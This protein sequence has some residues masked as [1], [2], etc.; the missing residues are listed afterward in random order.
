MFSISCWLKYHFVASS[1]LLQLLLQLLPGL[2]EESIPVVESVADQD[3][4]IN[5]CG[6]R[7]FANVDR[8]LL[9]IVGKGGSFELGVVDTLGLELLDQLGTLLLILG[10]LVLAVLGNVASRLDG[11][12]A[13]D[14]GLVGSIQQVAA[15]S[16]HVAEVVVG[17]GKVV[18]DGDLTVTHGLHGAALER[19]VEGFAGVLNVRLAVVTREVM[20]VLVAEAATDLSASAGGATDYTSVQIAA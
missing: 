12:L 10:D 17:S 7:E 14:V 11:Q 8:S 15:T 4:M 18:V 19:A 6:L 1:T 3:R 16:I 9:Q 2:L 13:E 5:R 20:N